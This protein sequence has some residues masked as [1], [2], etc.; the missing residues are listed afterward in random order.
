MGISCLLRLFIMC[1]LKLL[2][3][4]LS[5]FLL[6]L[7]R[8]LGDC[9]GNCALFEHCDYRGEHFCMSAGE[10]YSNLK[11]FNDKISSTK[12]SSSGC[13][14]TIYEHSN[15]RGQSARTSRN[16]HCLNRIWTDQISSI[17]CTCP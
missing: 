15:F 13:S 11:W 8:C 4:V 7:P 9:R 3:V 2:L 6:V 1:S 17:K 5:G 14:M 12:V 16:N 10:S